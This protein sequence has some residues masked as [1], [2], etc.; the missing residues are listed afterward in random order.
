MASPNPLLRRKASEPTFKSAQIAPPQ[1]ARPSNFIQALAEEPTNKTGEGRLWQLEALLTLTLR[2]PQWKSVP[3][4]PGV[5]HHHD[6]DQTS[7]ERPHIEGEVGGLGE[8]SASTPKNTAYILL[9]L[10]VGSFWG[11]PDETE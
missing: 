2:L 3:S 6:H 11:I 5:A 10:D 9:P 7:A 1:L 8:E 4:A